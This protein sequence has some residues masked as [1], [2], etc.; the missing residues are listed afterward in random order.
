MKLL[1]NKKREELILLREENRQLRE[2]NA[3]LR[4]GLAHFAEQLAAAAARIEAAVSLPEQ[5]NTGPTLPEVNDHQ[6]HRSDLG[7]Y[8]EQHVPQV[9]EAAMIPTTSTDEIQ[10]S[11]LPCAKS[12]QQNSRGLGWLPGL[13]VLASLGLLL[14]ALADT[15]ARDSVTWAAPLFW[16]GILVMYAPIVLRMVSS[17]PTQ[18]ERIGLVLVVG[19]SLYLVKVL[20]SPL[21]FSFH[22]EFIHWATANDILATG[23][24]FSN[25][26]L[27]PI[28]PLFPGLESVTAAVSATTG[29]TVFTAGILVLAGA[30]AVLV[31]A[32]YGLYQHISNSPR[33]AGIASLLYV[34]NPNYVFFD[35]QFGYESLALPLAAMILYAEVRRTQ[36][37]ASERIGLAA[38]SLLGIGGLVITHHVTT[39]ALAGFLVL[40]TTVAFLKTYSLHFRGALSDCIRWYGGEI[41]NSQAFRSVRSRIT[42]LTSRAESR[43]QL[44]VGTTALL[45]LIGSFAWL[46]FV[47]GPTSK[48]LSGNIVGGIRELARFLLGQQPGR[49]LFL[50]YGGDSAPPWEQW[51][52]FSS[53]GLILLALVWALIRLWKRYQHN[54]VVLALGL[55]VSLYPM[56]L[57]FRLTDQGAQISG[58]AWEFL[59]VSIAFALA[60][61]MEELAQP[62][63]QR[64]VRALTISALASIILVGGIIVGR[65]AW[66]RM[67][68][69]YLVG[70]DPRSIESEGIAAARWSLST[71]GPGRRMLGDRVSRLLM[72]TYG[73]QR[74]ITEIGNQIAGDGAPILLTPEVRPEQL[75]DLQRA[76]LEY[77]VVDQRLSTALPKLGFYVGPSE[78]EAFKHTRPIDS[79][80]LRKFD[81][82]RDVNRVFDSG[83]IIVYD[84]VRFLHAQVR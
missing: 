9:D 11:P 79:A 53:V 27:L 76:R 31:L 21:R 24:L 20:Y 2:E 5:P 84:L 36:A 54:P 74:P 67:P 23:R 51:I 64:V 46:Y 22:D 58:R 78:P 4:Q 40:W 47:A 16:V 82:L 73:H 1:N 18:Y 44:T 63:R 45:A 12:E 50:S 61:V 69:P 10:A 6:V 57:A 52:A 43:S 75:E 49:V 65:P 30:R 25:N 72:A 26:F 42:S 37:A 14:V 56:T 55:G 39:Y 19:L 29:L 48:Y 32:L 66:M 38:L 83:N 70:A 59:F 15:G 3:R 35:A 60:V 77:L 71:L 68:G 8:E 81:D 7:Q 41:S 33:I 13:S 28:S 34:A 17:R 80:A 62:S